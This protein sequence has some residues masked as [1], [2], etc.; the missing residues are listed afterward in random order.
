MKSVEVSA[1]EIKCVAAMR[2]A[3]MSGRRNE[4]I[5]RRINGSLIENELKKRA[6]L[7]RRNKRSAWG[8]RAVA[9]TLLWH[10]GGGAGKFVRIMTRWEKRPLHFVFIQWNFKLHSRPA[11]AKS[12]AMKWVQLE[13][14]YFVNEICRRTRLLPLV[15]FN[16]ISCTSGIDC[17]I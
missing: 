3:W 2:I 8:G 16:T 10:L 7:C 5:G 14:I 11:H 12:I 15:S 13:Y 6:I 1:G 4:A 17:L 9:K